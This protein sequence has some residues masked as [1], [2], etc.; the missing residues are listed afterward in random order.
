[1]PPG[2]FIRDVPKRIGDG[3]IASSS[4]DPRRIGGYRQA[5][6]AN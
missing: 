2:H 4:I 3:A 1:M 6:A 5:L